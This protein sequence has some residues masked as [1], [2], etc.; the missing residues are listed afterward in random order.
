MVKGFADYSDVRLHLVV[1]SDKIHYQEVF[2][3][4]IPVTI[5]KRV[6]KRNPLVF[7]RLYRLCRTWK[8]DLIHSWGTMSAIMAIP[9][10]LLLSIKLI[11]GNITDAPKNMH[12]FD[13]RLFRARLTYPFS[14][15][16]VG[17]SLAGLKEYKVPLKKAVCIYNG[18]DIGRITNLKEKSLI[19]KEFAINTKSVI[20]MVGGFFDRKDY[21]TYLKAA[22]IVLNESKDITFVAVGDGPN[23]IKCKEMIPKEWASNFIFTGSQRDVESI[24]NTF[25]IGV[26]LTNAQMHGEGISNAI[27]E[28]MALKKAT[29]ATIGGGTNEVVDHLKTGI[30]IEPESPQTVADQLLYLLDNLEIAQKMGIEAKSRLDNYFS[31]AKMTESYYQL[32]HKHLEK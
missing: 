2:E 26:L 15:V 6:P 20:G 10:S 22:F 4:G 21:E 3:L 31:L 1:F 25:D 14:K 17:N 16:V 29:L 27:L 7:Y 11:N 12:F 5:L 8:P 9:S 13:E 19:R 24:I 28:Y 18:F 30:L 23:L 32:Y